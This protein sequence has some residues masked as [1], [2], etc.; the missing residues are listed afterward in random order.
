MEAAEQSA[1]PVINIEGEKVAL[2]P[3]RRDLLSTFVRWI[4]DF[5]VTRSLALGMRPITPEQE[6]EWYDASG[7]S[8]TSATFTVYERATMRPIG[9]TSLD[10][11]DHL[12]GTAEFGVVIGEKECWGKGYGTET[13][14]L[15]LEYGFTCLGLHSVMLH[16]HSY[17]RRAI[18]AYQRA[19]FREAG[20]I[21]ECHRLGQKFYDVLLMDCLSTEFDG[22]YLRRLLPGS[23]DER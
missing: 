4:N 12:N 23:G 21:R 15:M 19:G 14:R 5:G 10:H 11:I 6:A 17:N 8:Q 18:R 20:R 16:V 9:I 3:R 2:G 1:I 13:A 22:S 7:K